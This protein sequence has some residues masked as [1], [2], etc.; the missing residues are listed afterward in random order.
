MFLKC[1]DWLIKYKLTIPR[2]MSVSW[3]VCSLSAAPWLRP[4]PCRPDAR[5]PVVLSAAL[6]TDCAPSELSSGQHVWSGTAN[7][8]HNNCIT[9]LGYV[10]FTVT[11]VQVRLSMYELIVNLMQAS[12]VRVEHS[13]SLV[14]QPHNVYCLNAEQCIFIGNLQSKQANVLQKHFTI[15]ATVLCIHCCLSVSPPFQE[16]AI[17]RG[18]HSGLCL[19]VRIQHKLWAE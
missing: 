17:L 8:S 1:F 7:N 14:V 12:P 5:R 3:S 19:R 18:R 15:S 2:Q 10:Q 6:C 11:R 4:V 13:Q 9:A 16:V